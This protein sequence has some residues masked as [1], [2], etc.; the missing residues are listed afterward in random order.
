MSKDLTK[1]SIEDLKNFNSKNIGKFKL[2]NNLEKNTKGNIYIDTSKD[3]SQFSEGYLRLNILDLFDNNVLNII[4]EQMIAS[5]TKI[6]YIIIKLEDSIDH[7]GVYF[8][9]NKLP[10]VIDDDN[11]IIEFLI[12]K[13]DYIGSIGIPNINNIYDISFI[14]K[15]PSN[16]KNISILPLLVPKKVTA[17]PNGSLIN[18]D[19]ISIEENIIKNTNINISETIDYCNFNDILNQAVISFIIIILILLIFI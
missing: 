17:P 1:G 13:T 11:R 14:L 3:W 2:Q 10:V 4:K 7:N 6:N 9:L 15:D 8:Y 5:L 18:P 19:K 16:E 12:T